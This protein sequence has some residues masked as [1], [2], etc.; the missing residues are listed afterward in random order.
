MFDRFQQLSFL[1][2]EMYTHERL[3]PWQRDEKTSYIHGD[4]KLPELQSLVIIAAMPDVDGTGT[5][6]I[7]A[8]ELTLNYVPATCQSCLCCKLSPSLLHPDVHRDLYFNMM[9]LDTF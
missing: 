1:H 7:E 5:G 3:Y 2:L 4:L 9:N 8:E 6:F